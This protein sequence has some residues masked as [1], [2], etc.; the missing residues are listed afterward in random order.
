MIWKL[1]LLSI[2]F[3]AQTALFAGNQFRKA[4]VAHRINEKDLISEGITYSSITNSF[5]LSSIHKTKIVQIDAKS[6][7]FRDFITS[8]LLEVGF[9]G[10]ITDEK[11]NHLWACGNRGK[12]STVAKINLKS[13][14]LI[15]SYLNADSAENIYNDL[16]QDKEGNVYF[17]NTNK[18]T[19][20][21]IDQ[22][23]DSLSIFYDGNQ[24]LH[25]NGITISPDYKYLYIASTENGIRVLDIAKGKI[26]NEASGAINSTGIDGLKY[27]KNSLIGIQNEVKSRSEMKIAQYFLD[28]IGTKI[29]GMKIIDQN[30]PHFD[31]PT[32]FVIVGSHLYCLANSQLAN[33]DSN[34]K[35]RSYEHLDDII[36]LKYNLESE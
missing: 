7:E 4:Q 36:I 3:I 12:E 11:R 23:T 8:D 34:Y 26:I 27:Y 18:Q 10:M 17:T 1:T 16:V 35:I 21:K 31:I 9:L 28:E 33:I 20:Y 13:G 22:Q 6:G 14:E 2:I 30:G 15:K 19:V 5:F 29:T 25:P 32:T 24:I